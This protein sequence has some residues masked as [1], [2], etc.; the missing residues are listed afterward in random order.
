MPSVR[1]LEPFFA[2]RTD[3]N[4]NGGGGGS[5]VVTRDLLAVF[6]GGGAALA[7]G[8]QGDVYI[9]FAA[10]ILGWTLLANVAGSITI[11]VWKDSYADL[12]TNLGRLDHRQHTPDDQLGDQEPVL[13][14][15]RLD[16]S[17]RG[18]RHAP[19][20]DHERRHDRARDPRADSERMS[21]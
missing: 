5:G 3:G 6:D 15:H 13:H 1:W 19:L 20:H 12:P 18:G 17:D 9:P 16:D 14:P 2:S 11:D 8:A 21:G 10:T 4:R 7:A